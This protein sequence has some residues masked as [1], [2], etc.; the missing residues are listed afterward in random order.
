MNIAKTCFLT[1]LAVSSTMGIYFRA[2]L[3][4]QSPQIQSE[5]SK[6]RCSNIPEFR[7]GY[8]KDAGSVKR[9]RGQYLMHGISW[10]QNIFC[11]SGTLEITGLGEN[12]AGQPPRLTI[13][14]DDKIIR[15]VDFDRVKIVRVNVKSESRISLAYLND[16]YAAD[17]RVANFERFKFTGIDCNN[18][19]V[20][21]PFASGGTVDTNLN[22]A[23]L[24]SNEPLIVNPCSSGILEARVSGRKGFGEFPHV[25]MIQ[26]GKQLL[27]LKTSMQKTTI[28]L[29]VS[30]RPIM[31]KLINP[32]GKTLADR[33]LQILKLKWFQSH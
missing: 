17:V 23:S 5:P 11:T 15:T 13:L 9:L 19:S 33:N 4:V 27:F 31:I 2:I 24:Y 14:E 26:D 10:L 30:P 21:Y 22:L 16:Y 6:E 25:T 12:V 20:D 8:E 1:I 7:I 32:Y 29:K 28:S 18:I 3:P